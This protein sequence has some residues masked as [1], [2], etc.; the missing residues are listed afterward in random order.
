MQ[1]QLTKSKAL[2][3]GT[4]N[5][6][7]AIVQAIVLGASGWGVAAGMFA[8]M[9]WLLAASGLYDSG[10]GLNSISPGTAMSFMLSGMALVLLNKPN[11]A[12]LA[13]NAARTLAIVSL[14]I[15]IAQLIISGMHGAFSYSLINVLLPHS[16]IVPIAAQTV[17]SVVF[18]GAGILLSSTDHPRCHLFAQ[19]C[20]LPVIVISTLA[21]IGYTYSLTY[22]Q[23][24]GL[25]TQLSF[26]AA[27]VL[28][29]LGTALLL[30]RPHTGPIS[31]ITSNTF[32]GVVA[33]RLMPIYFLMPVLGLVSAASRNTANDL[34]FIV[35]L[36]TFGLPVFVWLFAHALERSENEK[37]AAYDQ[38]QLLN[39]QLNQQVDELVESQSQITQALK[40]RSEFLAKVSHEL[41]T[42][43]SGIIGTNELLLGMHLT[44]DQQELAQIS[45]DS[46]NSLLALINE[47]LD[48]SKI[49][50]HQL[51]L[52]KIDFDL[53]PL[54]ETALQVMRAKADKK[55][56]ILISFVSPDVRARVK[57]DPSRLRQIIVNLIDNAIKFTDQGKI[58]VQVCLDDDT[59][60]IRFAITDT[61]IGLS[62]EQSA[63][64]F[65]PFVQADGSTTRRYG[66]TGLGLSICKNLVELMGGKIGIQSSPSK[67]S[68]FWFT[69]PFGEAAPRAI[70][71]E[72]DP[73]LITSTTKRSAIL[74]VEDNPVN[75]KLTILQLK[76]LGYTADTAVTGQEAIDAVRQK[77]YALI[78]MDI[79]MPDMDGLEATAKIRE[80]EVISRMHVPIVATTA[81]AMPGD[82]EKCISAGMDDYMTKPLSLPL[83]ATMC[84]QWI[85]R[86]ETTIQMTAIN[87]DVVPFQRRK[88]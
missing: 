73:Q 85:N 17:L 31:I 67:G 18:L 74:L 30:S 49:D 20:A 71:V 54:V 83:L 44:E 57:G 80:M 19:L 32:G 65:Q 88:S 55:K 22:L 9:G 16:R 5:R 38:V 13:I 66:G 24:T 28:E 36:V 35:L 81:H 76:R 84:K 14:L 50:A 4:S 25:P 60:H 39:Q 79:Q 46:A 2:T 51:Q 15:A 23:F 69:I 40:T 11:R 21:M 52:E 82:R 1:T 64:L 34:L 10:L 78:L 72:K 61:G 59:K 77:Q 43:L 87:S 45:L 26:A 86:D 27:S 68:T 63:K 56:L 62:Q 33:R 37:M 75:A 7:T 29:V 41:R 42:P 12:N 53:N 47:I 48:F 58:L 6:V 8:L 3:H 70:K